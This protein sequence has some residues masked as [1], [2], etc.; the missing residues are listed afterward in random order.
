MNPSDGD[1]VGWFDWTAGV[2]VPLIGVAASIGVP[3]LVLYRQRKH[4]ERRLQEERGRSDAR[5]RE[6]R[7]IAEADRLSEARKRATRDAVSALAPFIGLNPFT[8]EVHPLLVSLRVSL[9]S[10]VDEYPADH[11]I[12]D[13][14]SN[15]QHLGMAESPRVC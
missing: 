1:G 12:N 5:L 11:P 14:V 4:D 15:H 6:Q 9:M 10:L 13:L 8:V 3:L 2:L 7:A